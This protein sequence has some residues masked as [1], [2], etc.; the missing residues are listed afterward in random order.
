[1]GGSSTSQL[2]T[3]KALEIAKDNESGQIPPAVTTLLERSVSDIWRRIQAQPTTY[4]MTKEQYAVFNYYRSRYGNDPVAQRA[5]ARFW[6]HYRGDPTMVDGARSSNNS[7][8]PG[9]SRSQTLSS[10][11]ASA[12]R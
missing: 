4:M 1:M 12:G 10:S 7:S 9:S 11:R 8:T 5:I 2:T 3:A 6:D